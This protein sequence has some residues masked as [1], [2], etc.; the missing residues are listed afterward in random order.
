MNP[1]VLSK[2]AFIFTGTAFFKNKAVHLRS[3]STQVLLRIKP[4]QQPKIIKPPGCNNGC[5]PAA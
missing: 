1:L 2:A 5:N 4:G 3:N